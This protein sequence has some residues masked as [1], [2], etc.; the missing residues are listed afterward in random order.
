MIQQYSKRVFVILAVLSVALLATWGVAAAAPSSIVVTKTILGGV[1]SAEPGDVITYRID[2]GNTPGGG[3]AN[4][5]M[6]DTLPSGVKLAGKPSLTVVNAP[7]NSIN[8]D[9]RGDLIGWRGDIGNGGRVYIDIPVVIDDCHDST[10]VIIEN[11][12]FV[13]NVG[14]AGVLSDSASVTV[15][16]SSSV[17]L[18]DIVWSIEVAEE[19][20]AP[21]SRMAGRK[22]P[23]DA[24]WL[25][26]RFENT[27]NFPVTTLGFLKLGDIK[28]EFQAPTLSWNGCLTCTR[29]TGASYIEQIGIDSFA[30]EVAP[31]DGVEGWVVF[32]PNGEPVDGGIKPIEFELCN[33]GQV[34]VKCDDNAGSDQKQTQ[35]AN[36]IVKRRDLGDAPDNSNNIGVN[37]LAY[38]AVGAGAPTD[39]RFP[40]VFNPAAGAIQGPAHVRSGMF[41][42]GMNVSS[43]READIGADQD[44]VNNID[45]ATNTP[46]QDAG[47]DGVRPNAWAFNNCTTDVI[48]VRVFIH[49]LAV[50]Y[51]NDNGEKAYINV[52]LDSNRDGDWADSFPACGVPSAEHI[53]INHG[54]NV[55]TLGA[56][57]HTIN[58]PT[59][60]AV[61]WPAPFANAPAWARVTLS[62]REVPTGLSIGGV[63]Y[64][65]GRSDGT[66]Y[67]TGETEDYLVNQNGPVLQA[68]LVG[69]L[70]GGGGD[71]AEMAWR[72]RLGNRGNQAATGLLV[73][74]NLPGQTVSNIAVS[75]PAI[76]CS[77]DASGVF[78]IADNIPAGGKAAVTIKTS[79]PSGSS[80][81]GNAA[82]D[83]DNATEALS[84]DS[85]NVPNAGILILNPAPNAIVGAAA[86]PIFEVQVAPNPA[87]GATP[88]NIFVDD[89]FVGNGMADADGYFKIEM[90]NLSVVGRHAL[91]VEYAGG[92]AESTFVVDPHHTANLASFTAQPCT[93]L[94]ECML[95]KYRPDFGNDIDPTVQFELPMTVGQPYKLEVAAPP[96][97]EFSFNYTEVKKAGEDPLEY[98]VHIMMSYNENDGT[99]SGIFTPTVTTRGVFAKLDGIVALP[100]GE[101]TQFTVGIN[102][103]GQDTTVVD[104]KTGDPLANS[105]A[106]LYAEAEPNSYIKLDMGTTP[107]KFH[108]SND[109]TRWV[110]TAPGYQP[111]VEEFSF[112]VEREF[113]SIPLTPA[114]A[115]RMDTQEISIDTDGFG[116]GYLEVA[117]GTV[118]SFIN[119]DTASH[120]VVGG[121]LDSGVLLS[122]ASYQWQFDTVG[123]YTIADPQNPENVAT[124]VVTATP[125]AVTLN[126]DLGI[127]NDELGTAVVMLLGLLMTAT[128]VVYKRQD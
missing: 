30:I 61:A 25:Y 52:W 111:R 54:I 20:D 94:Q 66:L 119:A 90:E 81:T 45:P 68:Q 40:T 10:P 121:D 118:I 89:Q 19:S 13:S 96:D 115:T 21:N 113:S 85:V 50:S 117:P 126:G 7:V 58:V 91:R 42:L 57:V 34:D 46:N 56:G 24:G 125:T 47:D 116:P 6:T 114:F 123:T 43:E 106:A 100:T 33:P 108:A 38:P 95:T 82:V 41:H 80:Y 26:M 103:N 78:C 71:P 48:P 65:D 97:S 83:A 104:A 23:R 127:G 124:I 107:T 72:L 31:N 101:T 28:G 62:E 15:D 4:V 22:V 8:R 11:T 29:G 112:G 69:G 77:V 88:I 110:F 84:N 55:T 92:S 79:A 44:L 75:N 5:L 37:M 39:G 64:G 27:T 128:I 3:V 59:T 98:I 9:I 17:S 67:Q 12:A 60:V 70:L 63:D 105:M 16:C 102:L 1:T 120:G 122:G 32:E 93:S 36:F 76:S 74:I 2:I 49:P 18:N 99:Y 14:G 87:R 73:D 109:A 86:K 51:F 35:T 53:V